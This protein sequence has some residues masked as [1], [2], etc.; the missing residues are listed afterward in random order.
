[1]NKVRQ[2]EHCDKMTKPANTTHEAAERTCEDEDL[3][4]GLTF[5]ESKGT[6][7]TKLTKKTLS[8][9]LKAI[10]NGAPISSACVIAGIANSTLTEWRKEHPEIDER[11]EL[12][13]ERMRETLLARVKLAAEDDWRASVELLK[14]SFA[15]D[16]RRVAQPQSPQQ[17]LHVHGDTV[18]LS[19]ERQA[20]LREQR[21]R[22]LATTKGAH[23]LGGVTAGVSE[24]IELQPEQPQATRIQPQGLLVRDAQGRGQPEVDAEIAG[25]EEQQSEQ[26]QPEPTWVKDWHKA[27]DARRDYNEADDAREAWFRLLR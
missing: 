17:H 10:S 22:I 2:K 23:V 15:S 18:V 8:R 26:P 21:R 9:L 12:A 6:K 11:V 20:E 13:R 25:E 24:E 19:P 3:T 7:P 16:Y 5:P 1:M 27:A 4:Q 14:L